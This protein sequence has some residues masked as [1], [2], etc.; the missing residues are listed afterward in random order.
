[1]KK[2]TIVISSFVL[3]IVIAVIACNSKKTPSANNEGMVAEVSQDSLIR[4]GEYLV[5]IMGCHD[6]HSP[7]KMTP[8]GP[9]IDTAY[10]LAGHPAKLPLPPIDPSGSKGWIMMS[11]TVTAMAGP[12]GISY[13]ANITSDASGIGNW[14]EAQFFKA[15]REGKYKGMDNTRPLLPPMPWDMIGKATDHDLRS[16]F[17]YLKSTPPVDNVVPAAVPPGQF[18]SMKIN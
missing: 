7:K 13:S 3:L 15:I 12:W 18:A 9:A 10:M 5:N 14:T 16:I 11:P 4:H 2:Y 1:M 6:C 8:T 17:A